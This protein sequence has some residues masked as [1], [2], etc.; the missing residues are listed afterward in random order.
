MIRTAGFVAA[1]A[2]AG[3]VGVLS[4]GAAHAA[5]GTVSIN[6]TNYDNPT[7]CIDPASAGGN[8]VNGVQL[9]TIVGNSTDKLVEVYSGRNCTGSVVGKVDPNGVTMVPHGSLRIVE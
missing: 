6:G 1:V 9:Q 4:A 5:Q 7:G 2:A 3:V 8:A